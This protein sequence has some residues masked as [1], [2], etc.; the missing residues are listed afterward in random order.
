MKTNLLSKAMILLA[1]AS[2]SF[3]SCEED[4]TTPDI[5]INNLKGMFVVCEGGF[6]TSDADITY[7]HPDSLSS[8]KGLYEKANGASLGS[9]LQSFTVVDTMGFL[10]VT[11]SQ[12][13]TVVSMKNF[14]KIKSIDGFSYPR[15][16]IKATD[17]VV[18]IANGN[19]YADNYIYT[20]NLETLT[21]TD[22]VAVGAGPEKM[23][24]VNN[25]IY[26]ANSGGYTN[27]GNTVSIINTTTFKV[28][29]SATVGNVPTDLVVDAN[30]NVWVY[31]KGVP[32]YTNYPNVTYTGSA[33]SKISTNGTITSLPI[34]A[35]TTMGINCLA[36]DKSGKTLYFVADG[37]YKMSINDTQLP[38]TKFND[39]AFYGIEVDPATGSIIGLDDVNSKAR[40]LNTDGTE[41]KNFDTGLYPNSICFEY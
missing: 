14:K 12:K 13:V 39:T 36:I 33:I 40:I 22:S 10:V 26:V 41:I 11:N 27:S 7:F 37:T 6:N 30:N 20:I 4:E 28:A 23:V 31:C 19:G 16:I 1:V 5:T 32:D 24:N 38:T 35:V 18:Y 17:D 25:N 15:N 8:I 21:K 3:F 34:S 29:G 2:F 9:I